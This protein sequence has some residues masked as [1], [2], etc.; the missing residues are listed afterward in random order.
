MSE[1]QDNSWL[2]Q[3]I[4]GYRWNNSVVGIQLSS[5]SMRLRAENWWKARLHRSISA[6][7]FHYKFAPGKYVVVR[8]I[9]GISP[10]QGVVSRHSSCSECKLPWHWAGY[11]WRQGAAAQRWTTSAVMF[12]CSPYQVA[13]TG[14]HPPRKLC[15]TMEAPNMLRYALNQTNAFY[16]TT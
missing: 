10:P 16:S 1:L 4:D 2:H 13:Q 15:S 14:L 5:T 9:C 3:G 6:C 11:Y 12:C 8:A 7:G